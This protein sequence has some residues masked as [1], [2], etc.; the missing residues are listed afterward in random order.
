MEEW[1]VVERR[2]R[3]W[4][5][6]T[7]PEYYLDESGRPSA[8]LEPAAGFV[9]SAWWTCSPE[10]RAGDTA[11]LYRSRKLRDIAHFLVVRSDAEPLDLPGNKFHGK[12]VCQFEVIE[13]LRKPVLWD[14]IKANERLQAWHAVRTRFVRS[15]YDVPD[16]YWREILTL[17]GN[18]PEFLAKQAADGRYRIQFERDIQRRLVEQPGL[19]HEVG[20]RG[21]TLIDREFPFANGRR[22]DLVYSQGAGLLKRNVIIELKRGEVG[23]R[24]IEQ[25]SDYADL[26]RHDTRAARRRP[27]T[28]VVGGS[29]HANAESMVGRGGRRP[30]FISLSELKIERA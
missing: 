22:A 29:L 1:I 10:T 13:M 30:R 12:H 3:H 6:V 27:L 16:D 21:L 23:P 11:L 14:A 17:A 26:L 7:R 15:Y 18:D 2:A 4:L 28:V 9:P 8:D 25:V 24:A 5:W 20:L 19:L